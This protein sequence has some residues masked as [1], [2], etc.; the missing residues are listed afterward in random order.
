[1]IRSEAK[2]LTLRYFPLAWS[3]IALAIVVLAPLTA[4]WGDVASVLSVYGLSFDS[5]AM[6]LH[7]LG[8]LVG[9]AITLRFLSRR[10]IGMSDLGLGTGIRASWIAYAIGGFIIAIFLYP[11]VEAIV[12]A[13]GV[14]MFWWGDGRFKYL[15]A[16]D[17]CLAVVAAVLMAPV[18]EEIFFR[19][20]LLRA[21]LERTENAPAAICLSSLVFMSVHALMG[22]GILIYVFLWSLIPA[23]LYLRTGSLYPAMLMHALNNVFAY[24]VLPALL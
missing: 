6:M 1:M 2:R 5:F 10:G 9:L 16:L 3:G 22:P 20:Y 4:M 17:W 7:E 11:A 19:G 8:L 13:I 18:I 15:S 14:G 23:Y 21:F 12:R 24:V